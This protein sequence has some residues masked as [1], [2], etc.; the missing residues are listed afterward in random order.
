VEAR[1]ATSGGF[2]RTTTLHSRRPTYVNGM[3]GASNLGYSRLPRLPIKVDP[4][5]IDLPAAGLV[6][7]EA[8]LAKAVGMKYIVMT[9]HHEGFTWSRRVCELL[10]SQTGGRPRSGGQVRGGCA[11][12]RMRLGL[13]YSLMD[14]HPPDGAL[15]KTDESARRDS[16][17]VSVE[18]LTAV[19][20]HLQMI[21]LLSA[22]DG[23]DEPRSGGRNGELDFHG[24]T[25]TTHMLRQP[26]QRPGSGKTI[27]G[28]ALPM[29]PGA[30]LLFRFVLTRAAY[31]LIRLP[32]CSGRRHD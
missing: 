30:R 29:P 3:I 13:H 31:D 24:E 21:E 20:H 8:K 5:P 2:M 32:N 15:I 10:P 17:S 9:K 19:D 25:A 16:V 18:I 14:R 26:T 6:A 4:I 23:S 11:G 12:E 22:K 1:Y 27:G 28:L 7:K